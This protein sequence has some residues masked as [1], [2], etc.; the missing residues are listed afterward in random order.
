MALIVK[1]VLY[2]GDPVDVLEFYRGLVS[3]SAGRGRED[4]AKPAL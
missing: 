1:V 4:L 2:V 3:G